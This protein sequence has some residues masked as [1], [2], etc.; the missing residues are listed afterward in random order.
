MSVNANFDDILTTTLNKHR[1]KFVDTVFAARPLTFFLM[2]NGQI[3]M[4]DGGAKIVE[5]LIVAN[6]ASVE[7]YTGSG[8]LDPTADVGGEFSAA[9]Y[10]WKTVAA[11]ISITGI[12]EAKNAGSSR[13][14]DLLEGK[15]M[16]AR[17]SITEFFNTAFHLS[18]A[19][20]PAS[21]GFNGL[22]YLVAQNTNAVGNIATTGGSQAFWQSTVDATS[23][24]LTTATMSNIYNTVSVG[25]DQ[26]NMVLT[27]QALYEKY[28]S[29]LQPQLRYSSAQVADAGFQNL[30]FKGAPVLYDADT[31]ANHMYFL[32]TKY[33][34]LIGHKDKWFTPSPFIRTTTADQRTAQIFCYGELT[35]NNRKRQGVATGQTA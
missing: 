23:E 9:E 17:E 8:P 12:E 30:L 31:T 13:I 21:G 22:G 35:V 5:P 14:L 7:A 27:T 34:K 29:L 11:S 19:T 2:Q 10:D 20:A 26:P 28:E 6:N 32:N 4:E 16:V 18:T 33:L 1:A 3:R 24:V 15:I 25:N